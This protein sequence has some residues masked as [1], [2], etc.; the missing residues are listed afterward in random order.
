MT[1]MTN[2]NYCDVKRF[3]VAFNCVLQMVFQWDLPLMSAVWAVNALFKLLWTTSIDFGNL[4][5]WAGIIGAVHFALL[6]TNCVVTRKY[7]AK[8]PDFVITFMIVI[9]WIY[10]F[11]L[12]VPKKCTVKFPNF[13]KFLTAKNP[14]WRSREKN[15][16]STR[17][18]LS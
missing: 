10:K 12:Q 13:Q 9:V 3:A 2:E 15:K 17:L 11:N 18:V 1:N 5:S 8:L 14:V 16:I 6:P 4:V 7:D